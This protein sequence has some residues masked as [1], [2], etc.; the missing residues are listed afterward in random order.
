MFELIF[1]WLCSPR[2]NRNR[3]QTFWG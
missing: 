3:R 2:D 1:N